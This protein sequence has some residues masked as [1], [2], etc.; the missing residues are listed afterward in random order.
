MH[1]VA[2]REKSMNADYFI[3]LSISTTALNLIQRMVSCN[4][5][6]LVIHGLYKYKLASIEKIQN[7]KSSSFEFKL[8]LEKK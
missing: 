7:S 8:K 2:Q 3:R 6:F 5:W 4:S 1:L